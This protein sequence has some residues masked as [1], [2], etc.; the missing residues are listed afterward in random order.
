M[1]CR[2]SKQRRS[3]SRKKK[4]AKSK[5]KPRQQ[6]AK[7][8]SRSR[9]ESKPSKLWNEPVKSKPMPKKS[10]NLKNSLKKSVLKQRKPPERPNKRD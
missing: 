6:L 2:P 8:L 5:K 10:V 9:R 4:C 3:V 7:Q 1:Q